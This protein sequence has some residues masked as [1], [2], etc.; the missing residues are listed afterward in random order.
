MF[1][2]LSSMRRFAQNERGSVVAETVIVLPVLLWSYLALFVYWDSFRSLNTV[3][4][5]SYTI[6]DIISREMVV[7]P[8]SRINGLK[9]VME[10]LLD[11]DQDVKL[12]VT[13][14]TYDETDARFEVL[15]SYSPGS[16][17]P[18]L[19]NADLALAS[20]KSRIPIMS[21]ADFATIVETQVPYVPSF[22][23]GMPDQVLQQFIVTRPRF[24]APNC[25][26]L[27]NCTGSYS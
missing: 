19:T 1:S 16:A 15:W 13:S 14:I 26:E 6:S 23:V 5:A 22:N 12:R 20:I 4:K 24:V 10:F 17:L 9:N 27:R 7:F 18:E 21:D 8:A 11:S 25:M 2:L 3:Q